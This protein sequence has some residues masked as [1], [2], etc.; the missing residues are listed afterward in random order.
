MRTSPPRDIMAVTGGPNPTDF[1]GVS[2][3]VE[4][5]KESLTQGEQSSANSDSNVVL[6]SS[7]VSPGTR[8]CAGAVVVP[9]TIVP[10]RASPTD[11]P[12]KLAVSAVR[13]PPPLIIGRSV[14]LY[15][16]RDGGNPVAVQ[17]EEHVVTGRRQVSVGGRRHSEPSWDR[18]EVQAEVALAAV[19]VMRD[20]TQTDERDLRD[21]RP[22]WG[23]HRERRAVGDRRRRRRDRGP[24]AVEEV[25]R[26]I[27]FGAELIGA[28]SSPAEPTAPR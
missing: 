23:G 11:A 13:D 25:R 14:N 8:S 21:L 7:R 3:S 18:L 2:G 16:R 27:Y 17:D 28:R 26:R 15:Q 1:S 24:G 19:E 22:V 12:R 20:R 5:V 4:T 9:V 10:T 6:G